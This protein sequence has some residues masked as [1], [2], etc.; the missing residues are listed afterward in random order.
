MPVV[1][2]GDLPY[3]PFNTEV[4]STQV[5]SAYQNIRSSAAD[6]GAAAGEGLSKLGQSI[7]HMADVA[8]ENA[9]A[10]QEQHNKVAADDLTNQYQDFET[11]LL[12]GDPANPGDTGFYG[13]KGQAAMDD[14]PR[15]RDSLLKQREAFRGSL[16]NDK[17]RL[18]FDQETRRLQAVTLA[19]VGRH[20]VS[21]NNTYQH[22]VAEAKVKSG[23]TAAAQAITRDPDDDAGFNVGVERSMTGFMEDAQRSGMAGNAD[24]VNQG[25]QKIR[26]EAVKYKAEALALKNPLAAAEFVKNNIDALSGDEGNQ[27][28]GRYRA[29]AGSLQADIDNGFAAPP[30]Q[31]GKTDTYDGSHIPHINYG[32]TGALGDPNEPG[33][34]AKNLTNIRAPSGASFRV[35]KAAAADFQGFLTDLEATGYKINP[36][37]S[38]GH[39]H[40]QITGGEG[41]SEHAYGAAIDINS[42]ANPFSAAG[43]KVTDLPPNIAELAAKHNLEWGGNWTSPVDT[44]HFQW[45]GPGG[46]APG[47]IAAAPDKVDNWEVRHNNF[48]GIRKAGIQATTAEGGFESF[49]TPEEGVQAIVN[50]LHT[51]STEGVATAM[52]PT[53]GPLQSL[54]QIVS[55]WAPPTENDTAQLIDRASKLTGFG[56]DDRLDLSNPGVMGK[57]TEAIIRNEHGGKL[58]V[59]PTIIAN[60][61]GQAPGLAAGR[62]MAVQSVTRPVQLAS[63]DPDSLI[64]SPTIK[65]LPKLDFMLPPL[66]AGELPDAQLPGMAEQL[67]KIMKN[68]PP[69]EVERRNNAVKRARQVLNQQY[70]EQQRALRLRNEQVKAQSEATQDQ[71]M[72]QLSKGVPVDIRQIEGDSRMTPEHRREMT[73]FVERENKQDPASLVSKRNTVALLDNI[74]NGKITEETPL[75]EAYLQG[76]VTYQ[77]FEK[78]RKEF[79]DQ[80]SE[81]GETLKEQKREL[82]SAVTNRI[83]GPYAIDRESEALDEVAAAREG[84]PSAKMRVYNYISDMN[85]KIDEYQKAGKN[86]RDLF[87]P[88]NSDFLGS[89]ENL[90]RFEPNIR[91]KIEA[92]KVAPT[93]TPEEMSNQE[94]V[95]F[96]K[97]ATNDADYAR[98]IAEGVKRGMVAQPAPPP[99]P[100][101]Q[102]PIAR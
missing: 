25:L 20:Y 63:N 58:P 45:R 26:G 18:L 49:K 29:R 15:V 23:L 89:P 93:K 77:D 17:Q 36:A 86:P 21:E 95:D 90:K 30:P 84:R 69:D 1:R 57:V 47:G 62:D 67:E 37:E 73:R 31:R 32:R 16:Q 27:L 91:Q 39:A 43:E 68:V 28:L 11:K 41:L 19:N 52:N 65:P 99:I 6:F 83:L 14:M 46:A 72:Q 7:G 48:G 92:G 51:W 22:N 64:V 79:R 70:Q 59:S 50:K 13:K 96:A 80:R 71:Y 61:A 9:I 4:P 12:Y 98:A 10:V 35:N 78:A 55:V 94:L 53:G 8:A 88:K 101:P 33:W 34:E 87:N 42:S 5:P 74:W 100:G 85:Q 102:A 97:R 54:R 75:K 76:N 66:D 40:R 82:M 3:Q 2:A 60:A 81:G 38:G 24:Y 44:M 56:P